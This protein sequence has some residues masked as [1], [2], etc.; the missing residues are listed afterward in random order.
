MELRL[1]GVSLIVPEQAQQPE[2]NT[3]TELQENGGEYQ[4]VINLRFA[5][6]TLLAIPSSTCIAWICIQSLGCAYSCRK[7]R[8]SEDRLRL[9]D[10]TG[11]LG[12]IAELK[13]SALTLQRQ[14][15][16]LEERVDR[17]EGAPEGGTFRTGLRLPCHHA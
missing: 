9:Q 17:L 16:A 2:Q 4:E 1:T 12:V 14:A 8:L 10:C 11:V 15:R 5:T 7:H 3:A 6:C 13:C